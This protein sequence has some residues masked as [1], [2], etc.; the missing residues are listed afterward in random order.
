MTAPSPE[1]SE[2]IAA[3]IKA[4]DQCIALGEFNTAEMLIGQGIAIAPGRREVLLRRARLAMIGKR[5]PEALADYRAVVESVQDNARIWTEMARVAARVLDWDTAISAFNKALAF[6]SKDASLWAELGHAQINGGRGAEAASSFQKS[7]ALDPNQ[8]EVWSDLGARQIAAER[9]EDAGKAFEKAISLGHAT[10]ETFKNLSIARDWSGDDEGMLNALR[11]AVGMAQNE[12][13]ARQ[14][15]GA[16]LLG[17]G[18]L[19]DG[20]GE[21]RQRFDNPDHKGWHRGIRL[22]RFDGKTLAG[23]R[24]LIWSDQGLGD[25]ILVAGL[26]PGATAAAEH[27]VFAC[28]PRLRPVIE[29]SF[30]GL[31]VV[32]LTELHTGK[33]DLRDVTTQASISELGPVLRSDLSS[34][35]THTGYLRADAGRSAA[36]K[37]KYDQMPGKGPVVGISWQSVNDQA[38]AHKTISLSD[39]GPILNLSNAR[40]VSLQY[41]DI[42]TDVAAANQKFGCEILID[43]SIDAITD[44]DAFAAQV[45]AMDVVISTSNTTV[46]MAGAL[47]IPTLCLTPRVEG[48]PWYWFKRQDH[49]PWYPS[50]RHIWQTRRGHWETAIS[51][52]AAQFNVL[53]GSR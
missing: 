40:F 15:L 29:R 28:E 52:A 9:F 31:R 36:L 1:I 50:V 19:S 26:L 23:Q 49:S 30:P 7:L 38:G 45:A 4:V 11:R 43:R 18:R 24:V 33:I 3:L 17:C 51:N 10:P 32:S 44:V 34:F 20:W 37:Q 6:L 21:Y 12:A 46:H 47:N 27:I 14:S 13:A 35:K 39:W 22:P 25:Q 41:G 42:A 53:L 5:F 48:R 16:A 8:A 2:A